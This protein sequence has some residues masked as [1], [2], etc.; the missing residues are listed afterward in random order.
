MSIEDEFAYIANGRVALLIMKPQSY[1]DME[2]LL[3]SFLPGTL[4]PVK[5]EGEIYGLPLEIT[6]WCILLNKKVFRDA[7]LDRKSTTQN[8][9]RDDG[10]I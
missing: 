5:Y 7:G 4:D 9:G 2:D 1:K 6:N 3:A 10:S 8:M